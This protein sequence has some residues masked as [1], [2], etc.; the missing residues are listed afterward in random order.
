MIRKSL[1]LKKIVG[2]GML[3][4]LSFTAPTANAVLIDF[5]GGT[6]TFNGGGTATT[7]L[8]NTYF[9]VLSY[10]EGGFILEFTFASPPTA[11]ATIAGDYYGTGNDVIHLHWADNGNQSSGPFG[12]VTE[13]RIR[14]ADDSM[15]DLGGFRVSTN[16]AIGGGESDGGELTWINTSKADEIFT[17]A[18]DC[19]GLGCGPDPLITI[20][21]GNTLFD[22]IT[23]FSFTNDV[24]STAVGL[25]LD[26]FFL[27]E[28]GD[29]DGEDPTPM[30]VPE[31][32]TLALF[33]IGLL[34]MGLC[35][36]RKSF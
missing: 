28:P 33:G 9:D 25:G 17:L 34:G 1:S 14:K 26:N 31:P 7:D 19:W 20:A 12:E 18:S 23:W 8:S 15:F 22:D 29:P 3:T 6:V 10:E 2:V 11:F 21:E 13:I 4:V 30:P 35:R 27:D 5:T 24:L 16:T 36:R 32:G